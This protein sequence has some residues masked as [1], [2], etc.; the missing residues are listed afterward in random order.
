MVKVDV[1]VEVEVR[2]G[3]FVGGTGVLVLVKVLVEVEEKVAV[4][5]RVLV[6]VKVRVAVEVKVGVTGMGI[7]WIASTLALSTLAGPNW[8]VIDP[9]LGL[10]LLNTLSSAV[11]AP[12]SAKMSKLV[13]TCAPL[14]DTLKTL[15]PAAVMPV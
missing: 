7:I 12:T 5:L 6:A 4:K 10:M 11:L 9:P 15:C 3:V 2:V 8:I 13:S 14:M 1:F